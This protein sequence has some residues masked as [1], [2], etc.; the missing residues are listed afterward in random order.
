MADTKLVEY[1]KASRLSGRTDL[2]ISKTLVG[3]GWNDT[4]LNEAFQQVNEQSYVTNS[5]STGSDSV[6]PNPSLASS[7]SRGRL[8]L[9]LLTVSLLVIFAIIG[10]IVAWGGLS[11]PGKAPQNAA[12][13]DAER[14]TDLKNYASALISYSKDRAHY[15]QASGTELDSTAQGNAGIF[16]KSGLLKSYLKNF[17]VDPKNGQAVC[18]ANPSA[19]DIPCAYK[20]RVSADGK[21]FVLW[22][23]M[24]SSYNNE[25][26]YIVDFSGHHTLVSNEPKTAP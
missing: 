14:Q 12:Q 13:R 4:Q 23:I 17:P 21:R 1:I 25:G 11:L 16:D 26:V 3:I 2:E 8:I 5:S 15:P 9:L 24:E 18:K 7:S 10:I 6:T 20:Y 22:A 19:P